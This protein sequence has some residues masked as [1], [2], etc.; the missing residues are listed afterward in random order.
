MYQ[1]YRGPSRIVWFLIGAVTASWWLKRKDADSRIFGHCMRLQYQTPPPI[2]NPSFA[3]DGAPSN[4]G[5]FTPSVPDFRSV[6]FRDIPRAFNHIPPAHWGEQQQ[7]W[8]QEKE[9]LANISRKVTDA[10]ADLTEATLES[11]LSAAEALKAKLAEHRANRE[12]QQNII[13]QQIQETRNLPP[14][15][16]S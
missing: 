7:S 13:D 8:Q 10:M 5:P 1:Y 6:T 9:H 12:H 11:V 3:P 2:G 16:Q 4:I 14:P 15:V